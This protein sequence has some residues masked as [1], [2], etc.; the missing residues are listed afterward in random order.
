MTETILR[1]ARIVLADRVV[2]GSIHLRDGRIADVDEGSG[3]VGEDV[4]GDVVMAGLV[5]LHTDQVETH[6]Q[7]RPGRYW[8]AVPAVLAHDAQ[9]AASGMTTV[10]DALR[11][12]SNMGETSLAARAGT[13]L[14]AIRHIVDADL[15]RAEHLVHLRCE[16]SADDA[17][18][19]FEAIGDDPLVRMASL[20]DHTPGQRQYADVE[21]FRRYMVGKHKMGDTQFEEHVAALHVLSERNADVHRR[22][23]AA[24]A[25]AR[26]IAIAAH[27]DATTAHVEESASLGV[28]IS[29]FPT[30]VEAASAAHGRGQLVVMGA[31]NIVRGGSHSGNVAAIDL[32]RLGLLDVLSSDYVPASPLQ[33]VFHLHARGELDLAAGSALVSANPARAIGLDDRG[34]VEP[35]RR[36]DLVRVHEHHHV[37]GDGDPTIV[38]IVRSVWRAG[39]RVS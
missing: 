4:G 23:I 13:L 16:V 27:D 7:P 24:R 8:D 19:M 25:G 1:N 30:T 3:L 38:P 9:V 21:A 32:L 39:R 15:T 12:G 11:I 36:A 28:A 2:R 29:E 31:P 17:L 5:E 10:L 26:G 22:A 20:M 37:A 14:G 34:V 6:F 18:D 33:A 35:G